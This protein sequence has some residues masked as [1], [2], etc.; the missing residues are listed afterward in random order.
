VSVVSLPAIPWRFQESDMVKM[1]QWA[2]PHFRITITTEPRAFYWE[3]G[4]L[5]LP[6]QG[7]P[8]FLAEG[9]T[10][11]FADAE[12]AV[13]E[14]IGKSYPSSLGYAPYAG[15]LATTFT[16]LTGERMD[17]GVFSGLSVVVTVR[18]PAGTDQVIVG[19]CRVVHYEL[20]VDLHNGNHVTIQ[21]AH[22]VRIAR[23]GG[24]G[25]RGASA[26]SGIG[27][28]YRGGVGPGCTG[29]IGFAANTVDHT[30]KPC[31]VHEDVAHQFR[32]LRD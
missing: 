22:I 4:D 20:H 27:R 21:P 8:R 14:V 17:L 23:E 9:R 32:S 10:G 25:S 2:T 13:R 28:V 6:V 18:T 1:W 29:R 19:Y 31:P 16:L 3:V 12:R 24:G 11:D 7:A 26:Y 5:M 30:G 15:P